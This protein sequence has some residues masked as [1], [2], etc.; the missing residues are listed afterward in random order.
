[1][2]AKYPLVSGR[3]QR[4]RNRTNALLGSM[5]PKGLHPK[6]LMQCEWP[7]AIKS[8]VSESEAVGILYRDLVKHGVEAGR[9]KI[10]DVAGVDLSIISYI[11]Y[12][13]EKILSQDAQKLL[14]FL[15]ARRQE[16]ALVK[17]QLRGG[18][19]AP[20]DNTDGARGGISPIY[21]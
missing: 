13:R 19:I 10:I 21:P 17:S 3:E 2:L 12:S 5:K 8:V 9:F 11:V 15:R 4:T 7:D 16:N 20:V 1:M 18:R 6:V 14:G